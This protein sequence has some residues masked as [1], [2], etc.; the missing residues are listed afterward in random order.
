M[1]QFIFF[2]AA[3]NRLFVR[4]DAETATWSV[5]GM[6]LTAEFPFVK[7]KEIARGMRVGFLDD[8]GIF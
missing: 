5:K 4:D 6:Q 1:M 8:D 3:D 2:D 7:E